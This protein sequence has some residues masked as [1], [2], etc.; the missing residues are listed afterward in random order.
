MLLPGGAG[1]GVWDEVPISEAYAKTGRK[2]V[3]GKWVD[4]NK[5]DTAEPN[6]RS[7]WVAREIATYKDEE[8]CAATPPLEALRYMLS[9]SATGKP[10]EE[11]RKILMLAEFR[12]REELKVLW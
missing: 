4:K 6:I 8:F 9:T 11:E 1:L 3:G 5:G 7:R 10:G 2:P 12:R